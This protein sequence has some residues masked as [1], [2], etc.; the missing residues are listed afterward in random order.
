MRIK[1]TY[2][3]WVTDM[4]RPKYSSIRDWWKKIKDCIYSYNG[5]Y[6]AAVKKEYSVFDI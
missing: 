3:K 1:I 2:S 5:K 4:K 6:C